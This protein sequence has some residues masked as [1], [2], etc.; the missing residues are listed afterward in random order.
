MDGPSEIREFLNRTPL[1]V[2]TC[3]S[4]GN[5]DL[6]SGRIEGKN[7]EHTVRTLGRLYNVDDFNN[8]ILKDDGGS[9]VRFKDIG[10]AELFPENERTLLKRD[11]E[12]MVNVVI[13]P[14][15]GANYID[16]VDECYKRIEEI[17]KDIPKDI[18]TYLGFDSTEFI[19][20]S[21]KEVEETIFLAFILVI[22][23]IFVFLRD[24]RTTLIPILAIPIS[25]IGTFFIMYLFNFTIN[26]LT[27]L[28]IVLAIG[29]VVDDAIVVLENIYKKIEMGMSPI[30][31]GVKGSAEI[32]F[33][34]IA[35]T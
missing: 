31:A 33:A 4:T 10:Y 27:L 23:I 35:T 13:V 17:K 18:E 30:E 15:P 19:R 6:P 3:F 5:I 22:L 26:V 8:L 28:G 2:G 12:A 16:I 29:L 7:T 32:F 25:L 1:D 34:V 14:Q 9:V 24:W 21:I 20:D 11:G